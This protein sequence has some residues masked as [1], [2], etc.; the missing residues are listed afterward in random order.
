MSEQTPT[1]EVN[2]N[3][4]MPRLPRK[5]PIDK[6]EWLSLKQAWDLCFQRGKAVSYKRL[7]K[8]IRLGHIPHVID[9]IRVDRE[10]K[11]R[12]FISCKDLDQWLKHQSLKPVGA[13]GRI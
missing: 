13:G 7:Q 3:K 11:P 5:I 8:A 1:P 6:L 4:A 10:G 9:Q 12:E 2:I